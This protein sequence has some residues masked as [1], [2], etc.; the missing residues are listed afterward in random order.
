MMG[1]WRLIF[2]ALFIGLVACEMEEIKKSTKPWPPKS[3]NR[4]TCMS[5]ECI[6]ASH[7]YE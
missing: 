5:K 6:A 2:F 4:E 7:R 1:Y 3:G